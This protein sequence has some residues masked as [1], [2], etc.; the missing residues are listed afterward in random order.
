MSILN[1]SNSLAGYFKRQLNLDEDRTD[2][3]RYGFEVII[4]ESIKI[5]T[6]FLLAYS[7]ELTQYVIVGFLTVGI[8]RLFSGGYHSE[9]Y[10]RCFVLSLMLFL[11][12]GKITQ[13]LLPYFRFSVPLNFGIVTATFVMTLWIAIKWAPAETVNK[14]LSPTEKNRQKKFSLGWIVLWFILTCYLLLWFPL[15][16]TAFILLGT[17]IAHILQSISIT[18]TGFKIMRFIDT[19]EDN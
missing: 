1:I 4:G 9:T 10:E 19:L 12:M 2:I 14:P 18:P 3:L 8:Y 11:G 15:E 6:L 16:K 7:L 17:L 5:I 13:M